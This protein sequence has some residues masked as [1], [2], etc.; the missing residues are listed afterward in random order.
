MKIKERGR[1][2]SIN[3]DHKQTR[4]TGKEDDENEYTD[5]FYTS[6]SDV[7]VPDDEAGGG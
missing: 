7:F 2:T 5:G 4:T 6:D 1:Y 3:P